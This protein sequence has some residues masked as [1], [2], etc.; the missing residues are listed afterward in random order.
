MAQP[1]ERLSST[2]DGQVVTLAHDL[3]FEH[4]GWRTWIREWAWSTDGVHIVS[5]MLRGDE[6]VDLHDKVTCRSNL[7]PCLY[8]IWCGSGVAIT[9]A[10]GGATNSR[11][12]ALLM[13]VYAPLIE[14]WLARLCEV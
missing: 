2:A 7:P 11:R 9:A 8:L 13:R 6:I 10:S 1:E 3:A 12:G 5:K 4:Q 14:V